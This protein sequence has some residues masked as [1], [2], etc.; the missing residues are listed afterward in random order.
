[1]L[2]GVAL[3]KN[4]PPLPTLVAALEQSLLT[5]FPSRRAAELAAAL[6]REFRTPTPDGLGAFDVPAGTPV[7]AVETVKVAK[8]K[9]RKARGAYRTK[10]KVKA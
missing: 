8:P 10:G 4:T 2:A 1:M 6:C 3:L 9:P 5:E 7:E